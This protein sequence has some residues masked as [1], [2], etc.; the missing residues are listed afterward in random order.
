MRQRLK[1]IAFAAVAA[2]LAA[3]GMAI[4]QGD[5]G[6]GA[7]PDERVH[8]AHLIGPG[9]HHGGDVTYSETHLREDGEDVTV[10]VD[11]GKVTGSDSDSVTI[12]RN[13]GESVEI[14][15][16]GDTKVLSGPR[17]P[18][19]KVEDIAVGKRV[20]AVRRSGSEAAELVGVTPKHPLRMRFRAHERG[21]DHFGGPGEMPAP[22]P[23]DG[24]Q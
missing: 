12:R 23:I 15:V 11:H 13:D 4:A 8:K 3:G 19:G 9:P 5:E 21:S 22:P 10:R 7:A 14:P 1:T 18:D 16:D 6:G 24:G 20:M 2:A 17:D